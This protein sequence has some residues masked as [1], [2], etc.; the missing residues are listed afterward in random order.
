MAVPVIFEGFGWRT[1][2]VGYERRARMYGVA[3]L[4]DDLQQASAAHDRVAG[5]QPGVRLS[6]T[7]GRTRPA[8]PLKEEEVTT[9]EAILE[10]L[11][12]AD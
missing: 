1:E 10:A 4:V 2:A 12:A 9:R 7:R 11:G 8:W 3:H 6:T 5:H